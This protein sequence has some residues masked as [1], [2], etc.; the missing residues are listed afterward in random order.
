MHGHQQY[1][2]SADTK[3]ASDSKVATG[4]ESEP[5]IAVLSV[6]LD[7]VILW[8]PLKGTRHR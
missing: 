8:D 1:V 5:R 3:T 7:D 6:S 4:D 2:L